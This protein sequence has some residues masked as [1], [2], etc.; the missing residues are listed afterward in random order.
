MFIRAGGDADGHVRGLPFSPGHALRK[1]ID[2]NAGFQHLVTR[3]G[4]PVRD[5][6]AVAK[7]CG[8]LLLASQHPVNVAFRHVARAN[9]RGGNL[10]NRL[11]FITGLLAG[12]N[13][14]H[15]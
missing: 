13:I 6:N 4:S 3:V 7:E 2:L 14:L 10:T 1:L 9:Q 5:G 15:R 11:F 12:M 8:G